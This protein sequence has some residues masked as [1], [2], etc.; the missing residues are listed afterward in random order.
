LQG[1]RYLVDSNL[2][3]GQDLPRLR[4]ALLEAGCRQVSLVYF[5]TASPE[6]YGLRPAEGATE[7]APGCLAVS[8]TPLQG[9]GLASDAFS[10]LRGLEPEARV[11][12]SIFLYAA[13]EPAVAAAWRRALAEGAGEADNTITGV[14]SASRRTAP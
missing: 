14:W 4:G 9:V 6:A 8:A 7:E 5:G 2:D 10:D 3:W 1:H 11:G 12:H 13:A